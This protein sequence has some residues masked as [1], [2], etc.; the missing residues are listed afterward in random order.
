M[1]RCVRGGEKN[2]TSASR[3]SL[4]ISLR[5]LIKYG[6]ERGET[7]TER[8]VGRIDNILFRPRSPQRDA[9]AAAVFG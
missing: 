4:I 7:S 6:S 5:P 9:D 2:N 8:A 3:Y 1:L